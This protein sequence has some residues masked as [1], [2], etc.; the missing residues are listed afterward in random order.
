MA[1]KKY[2]AVKSGRTCG[3]FESW[4]EAK[5]QVSGYSGAVYKG[6]STEKEARE[7]LSGEEYQNS[8][9]QAPQTGELFAYVDGSYDVKTGRYA[10]GVVLL[11][12]TG[13]ILKNG[14]GEEQEAAG[15]RNVAGELAGA[16]FAMQY[17]MDNGYQSLTIFHDYEGIARW[18]RDEWK[19]NLSS[20]QKYKQFYNECARKLKITFQKVAAHTGD[21]Y[22]EL[23]DSL[24]KEALGLKK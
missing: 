12:D 6:F 13:E 17:A 22:N 20:T 23:A 4:D 14:L 18:A 2:Y 21:H 5:Q 3:I 10:Y 19:A 16:V 8:A 15:M 1:K 7:F 9:A 11:T 24:A